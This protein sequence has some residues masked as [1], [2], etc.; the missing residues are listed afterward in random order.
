MTA[1]RP[2]PLWYQLATPEELSKIDELDR[3]IANLRR[4]RKVL[5]NRAKL[6]TRVWVERR[7]TLMMGARRKPVASY[8]RPQPDARRSE[9]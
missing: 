9:H 2:H 3:S 7:E 1:K 5:I 6:R 4:R 8:Q